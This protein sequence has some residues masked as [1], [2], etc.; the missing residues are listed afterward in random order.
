MNRES[1]FFT[2]TV[3]FFISVILVIASFTILMTHNYQNKEEQ[4]LEKYI[5]IIKMVVR[6]H[7]RGIVDEGFLKTLEEI[8]YTMFTSKEQI[9]KITYNPKTKVLVEK[10]NFRNR[11]VFRVLK[12]KDKNYIYMKKH[13]KSL[14][15]RDNIPHANLTQLYIILVFGIVIITIVLMYL[16]TL[17]KLMPL[18]ILKDKVKHLGDENF[19]FECC[20]TNRKDEVSQLAL[21]FKNTAIKLKSI[22][23]AR[24]V[25]IRNIMHELK[26]PITKG[27]FLVEIKKTEHTADNLREVFNRLESL[28]NEF[29]SIEELISS[30]KNIEKNYY[31]IDDIVDNAIDI[32][33]IDNENVEQKYENKKVF[34]NY[35][36][37]SVAVKN[38][39]DNA[40]KYSKDK[41]VTIKSE[42]ENIIFEN[43]GVMLKHDLK[44]YYEP[45]F[46]SN[47][48]NSNSFGLGLYIVFNILKA[49]GYKLEYEYIND[50]NIFKCIKEEISTK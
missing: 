5:P 31:Y 25:F 35:K 4:L 30:S 37:F 15:I 41:K 17:R 7:N 21:E 1:I 42:G 23:E 9:N 43:K 16:I 3:S 26:T 29:A 8:N 19:D 13:R 20:D 24:N 12:L 18:K 47:E 2:I 46:G 33:M 28:I 49:N 27:K 32:L 48:N 50:T 34:V 44:S 6:Q 36:L 38:I 22:K 14:L 40:I 10:K 11:T 45:F 39:I